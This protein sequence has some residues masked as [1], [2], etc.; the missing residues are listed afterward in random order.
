[1]SNGYSQCRLVHRQGFSRISHSCPARQH[2]A[3]GRR[4][5]LLAFL[6]TATIPI[7]L[8]LDTS[9]AWLRG[10]RPGPGPSCTVIGVGSIIWLAL[11][12]TLPTI[13]K[14]G[15]FVRAAWKQLLL[16]SGTFVLLWPL[17]EL[18][19]AWQLESLAPFHRRAP[20]MCR[21]M[22]PLPAILPGINGA[23]RYTTNSEGLRGSELPNDP[24]VVR[25]LC[26]GGSTT[27]CLYLDDQETWPHLLMESLNAGQSAPTYWCGSAGISGFTTQEHLRLVHNCGFLSRFDCVVFLVGINDFMLA[28]QK[29]ELRPLWRRSNVLSLVSLYTYGTEFENTSGR[30]YVYRREER[31]RAGLA[32][33]VAPLGRVLESYASRI[34]AIATCCRETQ[35]LPVFITQPVLW[36]D[37]LVE[38]VASR[39]WFGRMCDG[40]YL[41]CAE[42]RRG[43]D[44]FNR[45]LLDVCE[46]LGVQCIDTSSI[47]GNEA[48]F[49]DDCHFSEAGARE[50]AKLV[51]AQLREESTWD[52]ICDPGRRRT[53]NKED[54]TDVGLLPK[55]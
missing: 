36:Q 50:F 52:R 40:R 16:A 20:H 13:P 34:R 7:L 15:L 41:S 12:V 51:L 44:L 24:G 19:A 3:D 27:E 31:R 11:A 8:L 23:S 49:Y 9:I 48:F 33:C 54:T 35:V 17:E 45:A 5:L 55:N 32:D 18:I 47:S 4:R 6:G 30:N 53:F 29:A 43:M 39:L 25:I 2:R 21:D 38:P 1:M 22:H 42:L 28:L 14:C 46:E 37:G 10:W 26:I